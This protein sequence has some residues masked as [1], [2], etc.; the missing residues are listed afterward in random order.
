APL[1]WR[2][3]YLR[4]SR[5]AMFGLI[6]VL[7][8]L[9]MCSQTLMDGPRVYYL[10]CALAVIAVAMIAMLLVRGACFRPRTEEYSVLAAICVTYL[11]AASGSGDLVEATR[12]HNLAA[13]SILFKTGG[14]LLG[15]EPT[16]F[17]IYLALMWNCD[18]AVLLWIF[19]PMPEDILDEVHFQG[20]ASCLGLCMS[21]LLSKTLHSLHLALQDASAKG[22]A[23]KSLIG[24]TCDCEW[25]LSTAGFSDDIL[26]TQASGKSLAMLGCDA[27]G[28]FLREF[29][30]PDDLGRLKNAFET[31]DQGLPFLF[32][33]TLVVACGLQKEVELLITRT[34]APQELIG[35]QGI[36]RRELP[37]SNDVENFADAGVFLV[38]VRYA[39]CDQGADA[40]DAE[41]SDA[42][43]F[44]LSS[45]NM[46]R[47]S[48]PPT[49]GGEVDGHDEVF[50]NP[51]SAPMTTV[52]GMA[53]GDHGV[54]GE[55]DLAEA[56]K[57]GVKEHWLIDPAEL[58]L[59]QGVILGQGGFL[60]LL[61]VIR[62]SFFW[63]LVLLLLL[64]AHVFVIQ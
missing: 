61:Q 54:F 38:G 29:V 22:Q 9:D 17:A 21:I 43:A 4:N 36:V 11:C 19:D 57:L 2:T 52:T 35:S 45:D 25:L 55:L 49:Q 53:L 59:Q 58:Q 6:A 37:R 18:S 20:L 13:K 63:L 39:S 27:E 7:T 15:L 48:R 42:D 14:V 46:A 62:F 3:G 47:F 8:M 41:L 23:Y 34:L 10:L 12:F 30:K 1:C 16:L 28:R 31:A 26:I 60:V 50:S 5:A 24:M 51:S 33:M 56:I 44:M 32:P 40:G 64:F